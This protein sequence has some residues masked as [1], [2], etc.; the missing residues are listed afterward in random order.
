MANHVYRAVLA[1]AVEQHGFVTIEDV[2][3]LGFSGKRLVDMSQRGLAE[4][5]S[6]GVY[7]V[8][9]VPAG[10]FD[11][12]MACALWPR[13]A[14]GV[15]SHATALDLW[16]LCDI[17]PSIRDVTVPARYRTNRVLP[18]V[19]RLH[20]EDLRDEDVTW[21]EGAQIV[22]VARA[23]TG[24]IE[25]G[26]GWNL[27]EQAIATARR[28]GDVTKARARELTRLRPTPEGVPA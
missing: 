4:R 10:R 19:L 9:A 22:K 21:M 23:I 20:R 2:R 13:P 5:V 7:R 24:S 8:N 27:I 17:N 6:S 25:Q 26:V 18:G 16:E 1:L 11:Q 12:Y 15:L 28:R 14:R 3:E